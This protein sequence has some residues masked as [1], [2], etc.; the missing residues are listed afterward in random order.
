M[1]R[2]TRPCLAGES[3]VRAKCAC[4]LTNNSDGHLT[5]TGE[6]HGRIFTEQS[7]AVTTVQNPDDPA[8][9]YGVVSP[10]VRVGR[11]DFSDRGAKD[12]SRPHG[13]DPARTRGQART[14]APST[15]HRGDRVGGLRSRVTASIVSDREA[16]AAC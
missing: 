5:R 8:Y 10:P 3:P 16:A 14:P 4:F 11:A 9:P 2:T 1:T 15:I 12:F 13:S 6:N 7:R